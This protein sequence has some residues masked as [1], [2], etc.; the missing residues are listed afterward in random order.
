MKELEANDLIQRTVF[1]EV[2]PK[3]EYELTDNGR[4][5]RMVLDPLCDWGRR[6]V[7]TANEDPTESTS[8]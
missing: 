4:S 3:V 1:P 2:P 7:Q 8:S 5:L 6:F